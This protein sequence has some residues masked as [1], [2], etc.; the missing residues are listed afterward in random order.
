MLTQNY[1]RC[2]FSVMNRVNAL[3]LRQSLGKV[4]ARLQAGGEPIIVEKGRRPVAA[5]ISLKD[6]EERFV[7]KAASQARAEIMAEI[8]RMARVSVDPTPAVDILRELR[9]TI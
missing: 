2:M 9:G 6:F 8:D 7:E 3:E 1:T 5:L 4:L